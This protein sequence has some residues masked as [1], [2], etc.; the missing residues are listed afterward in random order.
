VRSSRV[1]RASGCQCQSRNSP[2]F[3]PT[4]LRYSGIWGAADEAVQNNEHK[5]VPAKFRFTII[6]GHRN[7]RVITSTTTTNIVQNIIAR[8]KVFKKSSRFLK[9]IFYSFFENF[10]KIPFLFIFVEQF[11]CKWRYQKTRSERLSYFSEWMRCPDRVSWAIMQIALRSAQAATAGIP[12]AV[13]MLRP[14]VEN[15]AN[16]SSTSN[17]GDPHSCR[18]A[19]TPGREPG[20]PQQQQQQQGSPQLSGCSDPR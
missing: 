2:G 3:V 9:S 15:Q 17:S 6:H 4:I 16:H 14:Q 1:V 7:N 8:Y 10:A 20:Q 12:T 5:K 18:Y 11:L 13:A 19:Q